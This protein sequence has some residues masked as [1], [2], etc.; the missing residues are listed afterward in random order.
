M[1]IFCRNR[2]FAF[3]MLMLFL[4]C[5]NYAKN[6]KNAID[7]ITIAKSK[8]MIPNVVLQNKEH[9]G[10]DYELVEYLYNDATN[11]ASVVSEINDIKKDENTWFL[12][13][14]VIDSSINKSNQA[15]ALR[16]SYL[17]DELKT[18]TRDLYTGDG[19]NKHAHDT[20]NAREVITDLNSK[21]DLLLKKAQL[22]NY[23]S[24]Y[25]IKTKSLLE[26]GLD[27]GILKSDNIYF[28][29]KKDRENYISTSDEL[30]SI[31]DNIDKI[32]SK[33]AQN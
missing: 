17:F 19:I 31:S 24:E 23:Y 2:Y 12:P 1:D 28:S 9:Y 11:S 32:K 6:T 5:H 13:K 14:A 15:K 20:P 22:Y 4:A 29:N 16:L 3:L 10:N 33:L 21:S 25:Y 8:G 26:L 18:M 30:K 7:E 27:K